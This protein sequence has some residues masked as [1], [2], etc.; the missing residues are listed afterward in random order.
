MEKLDRRPPCFI[1][2]NIGDEAQKG[3]L[4]RSIARIARRGRAA[5]LPLAG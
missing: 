4:A 3:R 5:G 2:V 1:Q